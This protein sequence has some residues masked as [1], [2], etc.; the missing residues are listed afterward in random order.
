VRWRSDPS[1]AVFG[2]FRQCRRSPA[3]GEPKTDLSRSERGLLAVGTRRKTS[4]SDGSQN[5]GHII[6][7][8]GRVVNE[9]DGENGRVILIN[10]L[11]ATGGGNDNGGRSEC[12]WAKCGLRL[13]LEGASVASEIEQF[14]YGDAANMVSAYGQVGDYSVAEIRLSE[15][16]VALRIS[17]DRRP[18]SFRWIRFRDAALSL[19]SQNAAEED[20]LL[21][22]W[23][24][25]GFQSSEQANG[26]WQFNLNC[27]HSRWSWN[28][29]WPEIADAKPTEH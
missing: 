20:D 16:L 8:T 14:L 27:W 4:E 26:F 28:S 23:G 11:A 24:I 13:L 2:E 1:I 3:F 21:L 18:Y 19:F 6:I 5:T 9:Q 25:V 10:R 12:G 22:P 17:S 15:G 7:S 29:R